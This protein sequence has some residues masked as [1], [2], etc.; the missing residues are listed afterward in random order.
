MCGG[1]NKAHCLLK[2]IRENLKTQPRA[3]SGF[4]IGPIGEEGVRKSSA[5]IE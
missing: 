4:R 3:S 2:K 5:A 1:C